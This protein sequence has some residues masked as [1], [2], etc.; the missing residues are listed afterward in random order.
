VTGQITVPNTAGWQNWTTV[1][2]SGINLTAGK[3]VL[4]L[5]MDA[6]GSTGS[7]ANFNWLRLSM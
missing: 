4:R 2:K 1:S 6:N 7:V 3:H 5:R